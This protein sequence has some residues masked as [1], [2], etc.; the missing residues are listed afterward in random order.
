MDANE[1]NARFAGHGVS[2]PNICFVRCHVKK[3][4]VVMDR[5]VNGIVNLRS[6][7]QVA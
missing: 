1:Q 5:V 3:V 4:F 2:F 7:D 6:E